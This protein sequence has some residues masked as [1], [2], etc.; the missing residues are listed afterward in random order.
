MSNAVP[1]VT[2][3][4]LCNN[5]PEIVDGSQHHVFELYQDIKTDPS[6]YPYGEIG[7]P[8]DISGV[9]FMKWFYGGSGYTDGASSFRLFDCSNHMM[10]LNSWKVRDYMFVNPGRSTDV[11]FNSADLLTLVP[12]QWVLD[13]SHNTTDCWTACSYMQL[14]RE[15]IPLRS[16]CN[17]QCDVCCCLSPGELAT[18]LNHQDPSG[19]YVGTHVHPKRWAQKPIAIGDRLV[20]AV[21]FTNPNVQ[22][23]PI[24]LRLNFKV[25]GT[26]TP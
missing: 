11:S 4:Q 24:E 13:L 19:Q 22:A 26:T 9:D 10:H 2:F 17:W 20:L 21:L 25:S 7:T 18:L 1:K 23:K 8:W 3:A 15:L 6:G 5:L 16:L 14:M 12:Q